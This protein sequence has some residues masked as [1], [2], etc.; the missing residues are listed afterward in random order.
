MHRILLFE[1]HQGRSLFEWMFWRCHEL[2]QWVVFDW[3]MH[4]HQ[5]QSQPPKQSARSRRTEWKQKLIKLWM[6]R[7]HGF[8]N[9]NFI[10]LTE[11]NMHCD[12]FNAPQHPKKAMIIMNAAAPMNTNNP[13]YSS[14]VPCFS[15]CKN[16]V[17]IN[18]HAKRAN[19]AIPAAC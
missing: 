12:S 16:A 19:T 10:K 3:G 9:V 13:M 5:L 6:M 4:I 7:R 2:C 14:F 11:T 18:I 8:K 17:S 15:V 1:D